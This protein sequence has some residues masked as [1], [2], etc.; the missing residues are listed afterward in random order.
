MPR[1]H[2]VV[3]PFTGQQRLFYDVFN[4]RTKIAGFVLNF[5]S[6][7][8]TGKLIEDGKDGNY[9]DLPMSDRRPQ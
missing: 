6:F 5:D 4:P 9:G 3:R 7:D 1:G 8:A 2:F